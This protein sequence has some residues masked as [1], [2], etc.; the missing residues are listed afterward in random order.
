MADKALKEV[1]DEIRF[2]LEKSFQVSFAYAGALAVTA[3]S[4]RLDVIRDLSQTTGLARSVILAFLILV[5]N[6]VYLSISLACSFALVKRGMFVLASDA[7]EADEILREWE[8][9]LRMPAAG[10]GKTAWNI[11][12]YYL[13]PVDFVVAMASFTIFPL[14]LY[15]VLTHDMLDVP[16]QLAVL[17]VPIV[18]HVWPGWC[19]AQLVRLLTR[20]DRVMRGLGQAPQSRRV[21]ADD[22]VP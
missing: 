16:L 13:A 1:K 21:S 18:L 6:A 9:F 15:R 4:A 8:K 19:F 10:F 2:F 22:T 17:V 11:D 5:N 14:T 3:L 20:F 12:S 7:G